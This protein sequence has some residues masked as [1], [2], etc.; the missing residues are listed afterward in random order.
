MEST[1]QLKYYFKEETIFVFC[2]GDGE[3]GDDSTSESDGD[4]AAE[5]AA[6]E[7]VVVRVGLE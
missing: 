7:T 3:G 4:S 5:V 2:G 1:I 6:L